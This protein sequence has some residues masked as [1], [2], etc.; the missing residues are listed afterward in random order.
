VTVNHPTRLLIVLCAGV[1]AG[2]GD[3]TVARFEGGRIT[4][5]EFQERYHR[6]IDLMQQRDNLALRTQILNNMINERLMIR[7]LDNR[8][9]HALASTRER[10][11]QIRLQAILDRYAARIS[12]DTLTV[13]DA[14]I[15]LE[16]RAYNSKAT[17]RYLYAESEQDAMALKQRL[18]AGAS[19]EQLATEVFEDPGLANNGGYLGSFGWGEMEPAFEEVAFSIPVGE[20]SQPFP[21]QVGFGILKVESRVEQPLAS[22]YDFATVREKL[23]RAIIDRKTKRLVRNAAQDIAR[24]LAPE[25]D[26]TT[27]QLVLDRWELLLRASTS[28]EGRTDDISGRRLVSFRG[29]VWTVNDMMARAERTSDRQRRQVKDASRLKEFVTGLIVREELVARALEEGLEDDPGVG[30][31]VEATFRQYQLRSWADA[32]EDTVGASGW[33]EAVLRAQYDLGEESFGFPPEVNVA[34]ILVREEKE[35]LRLAA[36]ARSGVDFR[37]LARKHTIRLWAGKQGGEL[38]FG[39]R[40]KYGVLADTFFSAEIGTIIGPEYVDPYYGVFK[41]LARRDGRP[42]SYEEARGEIIGS[43]LPQ[44]KSDAVKEALERLRS[45]AAIEIDGQ[46]LSA[47]RLDHHNGNQAS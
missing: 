4:A 38:G 25:F 47:I 44:R 46:V 36:R 41:V 34:E 40:E 13:S 35:A 6:T 17:A 7:D 20:V 26:E 9:F 15:A 12:V 45:K 10:L 42:K 16:F 19:F 1:L 30:A 27:V 24:D 11:E 18:D 29:R 21:M 3:D 2:C 37:E 14:E 43:L 32:I 31:Q 33:D 5:E 8:G 39:T 28:E 22:A 23:K